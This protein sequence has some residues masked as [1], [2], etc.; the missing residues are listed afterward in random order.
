MKMFVSFRVPR[1]AAFRVAGIRRR[2][3]VEAARRRRAKVAASGKTATWRMDGRSDLQASA[4]ARRLKRRN[5]ASDDPRFR[6]R[7]K[8]RQ[9]LT[10]DYRLSTN[11]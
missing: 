9:P 7:A 10:N 5:R 3:K 11:D 2:P 4:S 6:G 8:R 1:Q